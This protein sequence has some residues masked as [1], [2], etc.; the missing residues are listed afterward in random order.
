MVI[1]YFICLLH[2]PVVFLNL[3]NC[4][5]ISIFHL[6]HIVWHI[7]WAR[8]AFTN[9]SVWIPC[10]TVP[11]TTRLLSESSLNHCT[12]LILLASPSP[13]VKDRRYCLKTSMITGCT[14][15]ESLGRRDWKQTAA[16]SLKGNQCYMSGVPENRGIFF[17]FAKP[18][19]K[20]LQMHFPP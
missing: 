19:V 10:C 8:A 20:A 4:P 12:S 14:I 16:A 2:S 17:S 7:R 3:C 15:P 5:L 1:Y 11:G 18:R 13:E 6:E 9:E